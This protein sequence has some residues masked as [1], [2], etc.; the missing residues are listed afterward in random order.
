MTSPEQQST[1][2]LLQR[3]NETVGT[4]VRQELQQAKNELVDKARQ[5]TGGVACL[6]A[7]SVL[8]AA[9]VGTSVAT[10]LRLLDRVLPAPAAGAVATAG[11]GGAAAALTVAGVSQLRAVNP[12]PEATIRSLRSDVEAVTDGVSNAGP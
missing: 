6:A 9:S 10:V 3:L 11:F 4:L 12:V 5:S 2:E 7:A 1:G 8:G